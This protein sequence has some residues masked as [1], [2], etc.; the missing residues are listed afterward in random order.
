MGLKNSK[1][2]EKNKI[3]EK[4]KPTGD[5]KAP[6]AKQKKIKLTFHYQNLYV[7]SQLKNW[8]PAVFYVESQI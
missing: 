3:V 4:K 7:E 6:I 2:K 8:R 5:P 1:G